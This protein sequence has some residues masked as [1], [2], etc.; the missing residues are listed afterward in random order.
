MAESVTV[1]QTI[2]I[3]MKEGM[4]QIALVLNRMADFAGAKGDEHKDDKNPAKGFYWMGYVDGLRDAATVAEDGQA[5][6]G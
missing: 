1:E 4:R 5:R 3:A 6:L 2:K